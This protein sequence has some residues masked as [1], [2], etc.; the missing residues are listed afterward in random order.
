[1]FGFQDQEDGTKLEITERSVRVLVREHR[2]FRLS[3]IFTVEYATTHN[4]VIKVVFLNYPFSMCIR[5]S[6]SCHGTEYPAPFAQK[7][8]EDVYS[9]SASLL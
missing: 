9:G 6:A 1:M 4:F 8:D 7:M 3:S 5:C 2:K